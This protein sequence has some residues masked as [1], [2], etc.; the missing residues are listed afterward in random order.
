MATRPLMAATA[1]QQREIDVQRQ[2]IEYLATLAGVQ[3]QVEHIRVKADANN[4]ADPVPD[5]APQGAPETTEQARTPGSYDDPRSPGITPGSTNGVP[6]A[7]TDVPMQPGASIPTTPYN[8]LQDVTAPIAG[9]QTGDL[10]EQAGQDA[11]TRRNVDVRALGIGEPGDQMDPSVAFPWTMSPNASN[12]GVPAG[13]EMAGGGGGSRTMAALRLAEA[14]IAAGIE[15]GDKFAVTAAIEGDA[16]MTEARIVDELNT[17]A[18]V[19]SAGSGRERRNDLVPRRTDSAPRPEV[20]S[21]ADASRMA[22]HLG[23]HSGYGDAEIDT[24]DMLLGSRRS[25][26][27]PGA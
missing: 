4:P 6:A 27:W 22:P 12:V 21:L 2:Q 24:A 5:P 3:A 7:A 18:R 11:T 16:T 17:L 10:G 9:T 8:Q 19:A 14:R 25:W 13:G 23:S 1:A 20:Q 15:R 26:S